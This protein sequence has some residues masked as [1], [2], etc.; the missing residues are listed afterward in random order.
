MSA[1]SSTVSS[2]ASDVSSTS[3]VSASTDPIDSEKESRVRVTAC[4]MRSKK[5]RFS[6]TR[7]ASP[8]AS[9]FL[10]SSVVSESDPRLPKKENAMWSLVYQPKPVV[11]SYSS[12]PGRVINSWIATFGLL[13]RCRIASICSV[14]GISTPYR[15][16]RPRGASADPP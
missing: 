16:A 9:K 1:A 5:P 7:G 12:L 11:R 6:S 15:A 3:R 2:S 8:F 13:P 10:R 14:M 4:L